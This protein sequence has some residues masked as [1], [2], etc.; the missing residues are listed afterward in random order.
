[1]VVEKDEVKNNVT[2]TYNEK[3]DAKTN[4]AKKLKKMKKKGKPM[5]TKQDIE[6]EI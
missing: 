2:A 4:T 3:F 5:L 1:M 6:G